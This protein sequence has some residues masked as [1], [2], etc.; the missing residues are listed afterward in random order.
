MSEH[1]EARGRIVGD[2]EARVAEHVSEED[3]V[4]WA[5]EEFTR[6][7]QEYPAGVPE[8]VLAEAIAARMLRERPEAFRL[9]FEGRDE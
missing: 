3:M 1:D 6:L 2:T 5:N 4:R 8:D 7:Y 9:P